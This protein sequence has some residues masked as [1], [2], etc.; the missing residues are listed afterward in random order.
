MLSRILFLSLLLL[1]S[2]GY[3]KEKLP[4]PKKVEIPELKCIL[5]NDEQI[6]SAVQGPHLCKIDSL[7]TVERYSILTDRSEK[8]NALHGESKESTMVSLHSAYL[9]IFTKI[10]RRYTLSFF[11]RFGD[12]PLKLECRDFNGDGNEKLFLLTASGNSY[13][14]FMLD[15]GRFQMFRTIFQSSS[16]LDDTAMA[17][18]FRDIDKDG[19]EEI[20]VARRDYSKTWSPDHSDYDVEIYKWNTAKEKYLLQKTVPFKKMWKVPEK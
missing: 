15:C 12:A 9:Y 5:E 13:L 16:E 3:G 8:K 1:V 6:I 10:N 11:D 19:S 4:D 18:A 17:I 20:L 14:G 7:D 2:P